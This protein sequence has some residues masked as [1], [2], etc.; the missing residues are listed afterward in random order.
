MAKKEAFYKRKENMKLLHLA[1][2][3]VPTSPAI[4]SSATSVEKPTGL[5]S[6]RSTRYT[7]IVL[8]ILLVFAGF[9]LTVPLHPS[10]STGLD[11]C[12]NATVLA[13][14]TPVSDCPDLAIVPASY[15]VVIK[16]ISNLA[17]KN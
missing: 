11:N 8:I 10:R 15:N 5:R 14:K 17:V 12:S 16:N 9:S 7:P 2:D 3:F 13:A 1:S 4:L 6:Q